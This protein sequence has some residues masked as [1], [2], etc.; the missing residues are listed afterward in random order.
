VE[1]RPRLAAADER[2]WERVHPLIAAGGLRPPRVR[3]LAQAL[4][5]DATALDRFLAR[6]ERFGRVAKVADNRYFLPETV[7]ALADI[8]R[9]L[10][11]SSPAGTFTAA[12]F[13]DRSGV[14][15]NLAI[16]ILEFLDR[17]G[18]TR[19]VGEARLSLRGG[20]ELFG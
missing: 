5:L 17:I 2:L 7:A 20:S 18:A 1:H 6:A 9:E 8:A 13:K 10:A 14:G 15:R 11:A 4:A 12:T 3:E 19:R 16:E